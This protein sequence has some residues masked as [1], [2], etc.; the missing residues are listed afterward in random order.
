MTLRLK[1]TLEALQFRKVTRVTRDNA[2]A[3]EL[4]DLSTLCQSSWLLCGTMLLRGSKRTFLDESLAPCSESIVARAASMETRLTRTLRTFP[5]C[6][7]T[8]ALPEPSGTH[9]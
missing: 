1:E 3:N 9:H 8:P 6:S 7:T 4:A 5:Q 2:I